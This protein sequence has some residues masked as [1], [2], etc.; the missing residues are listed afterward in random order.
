MSSLVA[1]TVGGFANFL[2]RA[3]AALDVAGKNMEV[4]QYTEKLVPST[5]FVAVDKLIPKVSDESFV[6]P[7]ASVIGD[8][9]IGKHTS[10]WYG[11]VI[12]GDVNSVQIGQGTC[13]GDRAV[14][15]VAKIQ[16]DFPTFIG[17]YVTIGSGALVHAATLGDGVVLGES[18]QVLDGAVLGKNAKIAPASIVT[19]GTQVGEGE[20]WAGTPAKKVRVLTEDEITAAKAEALEIIELA[21]IHAAEQEKD[22]KTIL[23]EEEDALVAEYVDDGY[24]EPPAS[25]DNTDVLGQG[26]PGRI[27][28]STLSHPHLKKFD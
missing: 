9:T 2:R 26:A 23:E 5:R 17:N 8:V 21:S 15:H 18:S 12:R 24:L 28:R 27:F 25:F 19:P 7:S 6:A 14:V 1:K 11:A 16:G 4:T 13:V 22:Y 20:L 10:V 3:G